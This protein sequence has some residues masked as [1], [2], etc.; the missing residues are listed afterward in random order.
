MKEERTNNSSSQLFDVMI[1]SLDKLNSSL[2]KLS[3][4]TNAEI[5][6][7]TIKIND[8]TKDVQALQHQSCPRDN[9]AIIE[10]I[11]T[12]KL[13]DKVGRP[14]KIRELIAWSIAIVASIIAILGKL[15]EIIELFKH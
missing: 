8:V 3:K 5:T 15:P 11:K 10:I 13:K 4:F 7:L 2:D 12:E 9:S 1:N 14:K 6:S